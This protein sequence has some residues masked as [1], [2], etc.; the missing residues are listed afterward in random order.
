[1]EHA[2]NDIAALFAHALYSG[3]IVDL[4]ALMVVAEAPLLW[5]LGRRR[6]GPGLAAVWP[7]LVSGVLLLMVARAALTDAPWT[8]IALLLGLAG[9]SHV[10]DLVVR[11]R[12]G[13]R[14]TAG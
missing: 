9:L 2:V 3:L 1:M 12:Q 6:I 5:W 13:R 8:L 4:I 14:A 10:L 11:A 7:T